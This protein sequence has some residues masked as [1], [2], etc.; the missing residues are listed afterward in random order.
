[1]M[2]VDQLMLTLLDLDDWLSTRSQLIS[3]RLVNEDLQDNWCVAGCVKHG[4]CCV[5]SRCLRTCALFEV[6]LSRK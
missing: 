6:A 3:G 2:P 4:L 5:D 1:M